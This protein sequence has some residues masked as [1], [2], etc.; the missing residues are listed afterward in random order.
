[1]IFTASINYW[2]IFSLLVLESEVLKKKITCIQ[3]L[4]INKGAYYLQVYID[5][6]HM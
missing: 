6:Y 2:R 4:L 5:K 1:M 3:V